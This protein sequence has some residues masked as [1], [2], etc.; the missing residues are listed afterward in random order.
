MALLT[1][2]PLASKIEPSQ[3]VIYIREETPTY[4][5]FLLQGEIVNGFTFYRVPLESRCIS[6]QLDFRGYHDLVF[7]SAAL[8]NSTQEY[9]ISKKRDF[10]LPKTKFNPNEANRVG[11]Y[12]EAPL[13]RFPLLLPNSMNGPLAPLL[14]SALIIAVPHGTDKVCVGRISHIH[15][16]DADYL[17]L[18]PSASFS[19][20]EVNRLWAK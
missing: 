6:D 14:R 19:T 16:K 4:E 1:H 3:P 9:R 8:G 15:Q 5:D 18:S 17:E 2:R 10:Q 13:Q 12:L 20:K 11:K 7:E